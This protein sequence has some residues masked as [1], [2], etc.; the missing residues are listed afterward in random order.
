MNAPVSVNRRHF[1]TT[2]TC[3]SAGAALWSGASW[4]GFGADA[5]APPIAVF[6][7][8]YQTLKLDFAESAA[9]TAEAGLDGVDAA[10]RAGGEVLPERATEDLPRY[11]EALRQ[12]GRR[13]LLLTT[14]ILSPDS[15][16][17]EDVL[18]AARQLGVRFYRLGSQT[19]S[20]GK[21]ASQLVNE[22]R[23]QLKDLVALNKDLGLCAIFQNHSPAGRAYLGGDLAELHEIVKDF[24]PEHL[25][26]AFDIGHALIVHGEAWRRHFEKLR[27]HIKVAYVKDSS[28][29]ARF[30]P[31]GQGEVG[32]T[33]FFRLLRAMNYAAPIS[34]HV[35]FDWDDKGKARTRARLVQTLKESLATLRQWLSAA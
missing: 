32:R 30:V 18:R 14:G 15:A 12:R 20:A 27:S 26:V 17:A 5:V 2:A 4:P 21:P 34:M 9:V 16:H 23:A 22:A 1:L 35:E 25:G 8:V 10:V 6:S 24:P 13:L 7:K 33:D 3:A 19:H 28:R 11:A 31:F 29:A